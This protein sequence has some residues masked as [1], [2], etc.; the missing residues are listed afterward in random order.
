MV[1]Q[2][3]ILNSRHIK[4]TTIRELVFK[5]IWWTKCSNRFGGIRTEIW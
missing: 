2:D 5:S 3:N 1:N 4:P